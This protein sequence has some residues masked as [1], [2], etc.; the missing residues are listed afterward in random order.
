MTRFLRLLAVAAVV[1]VLGASCPSH[2]VGAFL[3]NVAWFGLTIASTRN[4]TGQRPTGR[5]L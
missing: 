4:A 3:E 5:Y 1:Y 2:V